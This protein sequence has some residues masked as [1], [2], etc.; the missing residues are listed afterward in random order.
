MRCQDYSRLL[1]IA[2]DQDL[3]AWCV[4]LELFGVRRFFSVGS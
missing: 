3:L 4:F 2:K 1:E